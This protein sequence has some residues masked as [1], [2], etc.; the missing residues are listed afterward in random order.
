M[1][2]NVV[3]VIKRTLGFGW[4]EIYGAKMGRKLYRRIAIVTKRRW[5]WMIVMC[6]GHENGAV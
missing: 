5:G 6:Y 1:L 3:T 2:R 4:E